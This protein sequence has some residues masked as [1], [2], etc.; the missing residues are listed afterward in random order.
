[1]FCK[2]YI[3]TSSFP[4]MHCHIDAIF[5]TLKVQKFKRSCDMTWKKRE[6]ATLL[7]LALFF[8]PFILK[9]LP[10]KHVFPFHC[11]RHV[12]DELDESYLPP[13]SS[14]S[15]PPYLI[16]VI[17]FYT[18]TFLGLKILHSK[19]CKFTT[20]KASRQN[21]VNLWHKLPRDKIV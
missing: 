16:F 9:V 18:N 3:P 15:S 10:W 14:S 17:F 6:G 8:I 13:A 5:S 12:C 21:S 11:E 20:K 7:I 2:L 19:V 1:M 4:Y